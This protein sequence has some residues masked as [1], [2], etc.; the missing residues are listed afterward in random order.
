MYCCN[1]SADDDGG[2]I[3]FDNPNV[4]TLTNVTITGNNAGGKG[5]GIHTD[6]AITVI[7]STITL[8]SAADAGGIESSGATVAISNSIIAGNSAGSANK[9][10]SG[11]FS[12]NGFNLI[13]TVGDAS[14]TGTLI[15]GT[16]PNLVALANNGGQ[17]DTHALASGSAAIN[18]GTSSGAPATD[19]RGQARVG[20]TDLGAFEFANGP[21]AVD[22]SY[23]VGEDG[24]LSTHGQWFD[25]AWSTRRVLTF[26]H[27]GP[28]QNLIGIPI[29]VQLDASRIDY[30]LT[31]NGGQDLRF[32]DADGTLLAHEIE[33]WNESGTSTVWVRIPQVD[34]N[35]TTDF[36]TMYYGNVA[37]ADGQNAVAVWAGQDQAV[38]HLHN[39]FLDSTGNLNNASNIVSLDAVGRFGD[40]QSFD[41]SSGRI[42][43]PSNASVD[44]VFDGGGSV[45]AWFNAAGWGE[46]DYGRILDKSSGTTPSPN[47]WSLQLE[48]S[49]NRL[50]FEIGFQGGIGR[51]RLQPNTVSLNAWHHVTVVYDSSS[52]GNDPTIYLDGVAQTLIESDTPTGNM[53]SDAGLNLTIGNDA[54]ANRTFDG[55]IDEVRIS[56][57]TH[58]ADWF[59]TEYQA[60]NDN[61]V[62]FGSVETRGGVL[63][64]DSD[65][66]GDP[67]TAVLVGGNPENAAAFTLNPDGSFTY[68][69]TAN[70]TGV[71]TFTYR[72]SD[73]TG[74]SN[75]A[76]VTITVTAENDAPSIS[77]LTDRNF[78]DQSSTAIFSA[79]TL[80]DV[81]G[82]N[83]A[84]TITLSNGNAN[85][86]FTATSLASSGFV[87]TGAGEYALSARSVAAAQS[88]LRQL[89]FSPTSNQVAVG[90]TV[91]TTVTLG[92]IDGGPTVTQNMTATVKSI[93]DAPDGRCDRNRPDVYR[94]WRASVGV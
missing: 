1:N 27:G 65:P 5:G 37:A 42:T 80:V 41:G 86:A 28:N 87:Q 46:G 66:D 4:V 17:I 34:Q 48:A 45:S 11:A 81:E 40:A 36:I 79:V 61:L 31:Q 94:R 50:I 33:S 72:V 7:N 30:G 16:S 73:G 83:V 90:S 6:R 32:V 53:F 18:A 85:G 76:T 13:Q 92:V 8:N 15:S 93:N 91:L 60:S 38:Y 70:F 69:P 25:N 23:T 43:I 10:V 64:N 22:D 20:A 62:S 14:V 78:N 57:A 68:S 54:S 21:V 47:G 77:G 89:D 84:L 88:A 24:T 51:W 71:D 9:D 82:D 12:S 39:D 59:A 29:L 3:Y 67:L 55:L 49:D 63:T 52:A 35:S 58:S 44:D 75:L 19:S 26:N 74:Q 56:S 2:G